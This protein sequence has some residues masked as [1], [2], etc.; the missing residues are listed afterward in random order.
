MKSTQ[1]SLFTI[2]GKGNRKGQAQ[3]PEGPQPMF[4]AE[5]GWAC[6]GL[7]S[8]RLPRQRAS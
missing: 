2:Q 4:A 3:H 8:C 6:L 7:T 5:G 1:S